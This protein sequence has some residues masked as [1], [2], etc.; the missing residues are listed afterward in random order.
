M[1]EGIRRSGD[2]PIVKT[3]TSYKGLPSTRIAIFY[4]LALGLSR[5]LT[6]YR[7]AGR[8]AVYCDLGYWD[9]RLKSRHD[10]Y[11]KVAVNDRHPTEYL[12]DIDHGP[13]RFLRHGLTIE[14][15]REEG[16][17]ILVAGMSGKAA[18]A[19]RLRPNVWEEQTIRRLRQ[20]TRRPII[21]RPKPNWHGAKRITGQGVTFDRDMPLAEALR[22]CHAVVTHHSNVAVDALLAGVPV[23]C[24]KGVA[25]IL[26]SS[27]LASI[28]QPLMPP[29]RKQWAYNLAYCQWSVE[30]M[31]QGLAYRHLIND[32]L[33]P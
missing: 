32:G 25:K 10:G 1:A 22:N 16:R 15:W 33:I 4:G 23:F 31:R 20:L 11:H 2:E 14:P 3:S 6:D 9:R 12:M 27:G 19:E 21:Y 8:T 13:D 5:V 28:E 7:Q 26:G 30:E 29:G 17:H 18:I 24:E